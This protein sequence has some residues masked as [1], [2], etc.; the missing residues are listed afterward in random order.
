MPICHPNP[1]ANQLWRCSPFLQW[2][3]SHNN[4]TKR[5][6]HLLYP[7]APTEQACCLPKNFLLWLRSHNNNAKRDQHRLYPTAPTERVRRPTKAYQML[8]AE[9]LLLVFLPTLAMVE[10]AF[11]LPTMPLV[12]LVFCSLPVPIQTG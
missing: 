10:Q 4:N 11:D 5:D 8:P 12:L 1:T 7:T 9:D 3:R 2:L 6:F